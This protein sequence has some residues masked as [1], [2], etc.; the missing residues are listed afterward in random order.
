MIGSW[1]WD[2]FL[3][4]FSTLFGQAVERT[5]NAIEDRRASRRPEVRGKHA[6]RH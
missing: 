3:V 5:W 2:L 6:K 1:M 4:V